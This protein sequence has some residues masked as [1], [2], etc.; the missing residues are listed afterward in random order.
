[1]VVVKRLAGNWGGGADSSHRGGTNSHFRRGGGV[2]GYSP[3]VSVLRPEPRLPEMPAGGE[4]ASGRWT[5]HSLDMGGGVLPTGQGHKDFLI[6][7]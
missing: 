4:Y 2:G 6:R 7:L 1:M 5:R 3:E